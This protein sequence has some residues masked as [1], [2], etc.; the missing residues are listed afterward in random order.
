MFLTGAWY[1]KS[2]A[3][4]FVQSHRVHRGDRKL[5]CRSSLGEVPRWGQSPD[6]QPLTRPP[7]APW[8]P[9][10]TVTAAGLQTGSVSP[11]AS[12]PASGLG[13]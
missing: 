9:R 6:L 8:E 2:R 13:K 11:G 5:V 4:G 3:I 7:T 12:A 1:K 10:L